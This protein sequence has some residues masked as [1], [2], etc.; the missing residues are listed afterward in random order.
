MTLTF[1]MQQRELQSVPRV[2]TLADPNFLSSSLLE[3]ATSISA[4]QQYLHLSGWSKRIPW[5]LSPQNVTI[6]ILVR[7]RCS[8]SKYYTSSSNFNRN[9]RN[10]WKIGDHNFIGGT[11]GA[12]NSD[13]RI[14]FKWTDKTVGI[15]ASTA[16]RSPSLND[17]N[18]LPSPLNVLNTMAVMQPNGEYSSQSPEPSI[19]SLI[20]TSPKYVSTIEGWDTPHATTDHD[21]IYGE[22][23]PGRVYWGISSSDTFDSNKPRPAIL[24]FEPILHIA[25]PT[26]TKVKAE[27]GDVIF[28]KR[29]S[30]A[31]HVRGMRLAPTKAK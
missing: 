29:G 22:D 2:T 27:H 11:H 8:S 24:D 30:F 3:V 5:I 15:W 14:K 7:R 18:F 4:V 21:T 1:P 31:A 12:T 28:L 26:T 10:L 16:D 20:S 17:L 6:S 25:A 19:P 23:E 13:F 9:I